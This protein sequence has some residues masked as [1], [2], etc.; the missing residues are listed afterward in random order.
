[1][2]VIR[3]QRQADPWV[4]VQPSLH[5]QFEFQDSQGCYTE[6]LCLNQTKQPNNKT[7]KL[8][9]L[10]TPADLIRLASQEKESPKG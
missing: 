6:K 10:T 1:M 5:L 4:R 7:S 2:P 8:G 3:R 9:M